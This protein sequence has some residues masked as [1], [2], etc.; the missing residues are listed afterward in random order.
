MSAGMPDY[1]KT[2]LKGLTIL[3]AF[4]DSQKSLS[5]AEIAVL[6]GVPRPTVARLTATLVEFGYLVPSGRG[7]FEVG[8]R[9]LT[10]GYPVLSRIV[11][12]QQARRFMGEFADRIGGAVSIGIASDLDYVFIESIRRTASMRHIPD[13]GFHS[14]LAT[15]AMGRAL[16]SAMPKQ[17]F[18]TYVRRVCR[19]RPD[20]W[21]RYGDEAM[22]GIA[23]CRAHGYCAV[24]G[25]WRP[26]V[27]ALACPLGVNRN[28]EALALNC[29]L[30][31]WMTTPEQ[32]EKDQIGPRLVSLAAC[33]RESMALSECT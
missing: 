13:V 20:E 25:T 33:I 8:A 2:L 19:F 16:L 10:L 23:D 1:S 29:G 14:P 18:L 15:T 28:G 17:R 30:Q 24:Y 21:N 9:A 11:D 4:G 12:R 27:L 32:I 3:Q 22:Q 31:S 5:N 26:E 6:V 7:R